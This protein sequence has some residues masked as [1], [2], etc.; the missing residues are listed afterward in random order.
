MSSIAGR[1]HVSV[2]ER[3]NVLSFVL[4]SVIGRPRF[5]EGGMTSVN[6]RKLP[7][8]I[9]F[10]S[11]L[12]AR[13]ASPRSSA[14]MA[15]TTI[16]SSVASEEQNA[17]SRSSKSE[18]LP[19]IRKTGMN[20]AMVLS[21]ELQQLLGEELLMRTDIISRL[22]EYIREKNLYVEGDKRR[23]I[24]DDTMSR[25]LRTDGEHLVLHIHKLL[26]PLLTSPSKLGPDY[27]E[28]SDELFQQYL[29]EKG[30]IDISEKKKREGRG[31]FSAKVQQKYRELGSGMFADV[32]LEPSLREI[33]GGR[34]TMSRPQ[35]M[36]AVW[37]YIKLNRL[38]DPKSGRRI[39]MR[40]DLR[41]A[42]QITDPNIS[43]LDSFH[44]SGYVLR[45]CKKL[46]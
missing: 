24:C 7:R 32:G 30:A 34:A 14:S 2:L 39:I 28:R 15:G 6:E 38:Q 46:D 35:A 43:T 36:K 27:V 33:C 9:R 1:D 12:P 21:K 10:G 5:N 8:F 16:V 41:D 25:A 13:R 31:K 11:H 37:D 26:G 44:L 4:C 17:Q 18:K 45:L 19:V 42:L 40:K 29:K 3:Q 23:F 22:C 20:S